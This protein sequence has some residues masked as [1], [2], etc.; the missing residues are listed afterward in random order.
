MY[1]YCRNLTVRT[2]AVNVVTF[3]FDDKSIHSQY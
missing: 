3:K 2:N 1:K